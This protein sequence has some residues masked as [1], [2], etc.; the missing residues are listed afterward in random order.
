M[1]LLPVFIILFSGPLLNLLKEDPLYA[2]NYSWSY[3]VKRG[4]KLLN[5]PYFV[6]TDFREK[7]SRDPGILLK[8]DR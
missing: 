1:Q 8:V 5:V 2:M 6:G 4:T 3:S 7:I